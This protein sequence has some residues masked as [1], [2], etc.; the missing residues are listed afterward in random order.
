MAHQ[1]GTHSPSPSRGGLRVAQGQGSFQGRLV[2]HSPTMRAALASQNLALRGSDYSSEDSTSSPSTRRRSKRGLFGRRTSSDNSGSRKGSKDSSATQGT[3]GGHAFARGS[4]DTIAQSPRAD[5][6]ETPSHPSKEYGVTLYLRTPAPSGG[7]SREVYIKRDPKLGVGFTLNGEFPARILD[8]DPQSPAE[9]AG[10]LPGDEVH[11]V[12]GIHCT[13]VDHAH[14][15]KL[16]RKALSTQRTPSTPTISRSALSTAVSQSVSSSLSRQFDSAS[17]VPTAAPERV[18]SDMERQIRDRALALHS[19]NA[20]QSSASMRHHQATLASMD[21]TFTSQS[22]EDQELLLRVKATNDAKLASVSTSRP[23]ASASTKTQQDTSEFL[24]LLSEVDPDAVKPKTSPRQQLQHDVTTSVVDEEDFAGFDEVDITPADLEPSYEFTVEDESA[25][26]VSES[27]SDGYL[28]ILGSHSVPVLDSPHRGHTRSPASTTLPTSPLAHRSSLDFP[29][30]KTETQFLQRPGRSH[31]RTTGSPPS[32]SPSPSPAVGSPM[33]TRTRDSRRVH[34][35]RTSDAGLHVHSGPM[36][37]R[38]HSLPNAASGIPPAVLHPHSGQS[39]GRSDPDWLLSMVPTKSALK[40]PKSV[41]RRKRV[42]FSRDIAAVMT[43]TS[44]TK[45]QSARNELAPLQGTPP[46]ASG[47]PV[48]YSL[49]D[50]S[51]PLMHKRNLL[52]QA[53]SSPRLPRQKHFGAETTEQ[54]TSPNAQGALDVI[55]NIPPVLPGSARSSPLHSGPSS[56]SLP[57]Q[58]SHDSRGASLATPTAT[59]ATPSTSSSSH[60]SSVHTTQPISVQSTSTPVP[61]AGDVGTALQHPPQSPGVRANAVFL[62]SD[63]TGVEQ[64]ESITDG[65]GSDDCSLEPDSAGQAKQGDLYPGTTNVF[66]HKVTNN[67]WDVPEADYNPPSFT[68]PSVLSKPPAFIDPQDTV[69]IF[70]NVYD[71]GSRVDRASTLGAYKIV[72]GLPQNPLG[73][74]GMTG[75]GML[76]RWGPNKIK[77]LLLIRPCKDKDG[78][79]VYARDNSPVAEG[80]LANVDGLVLPGGYLEHLYGNEP[81]DSIVSEGTQQL[82]ALKSKLSTEHVL[83]STVPEAQEKFKALFTKCTVHSL[84]VTE[85][86]R[87]TDNAWVEPEVHVCVAQDDLFH[88]FSSKFTLSIGGL[89]LNLAW[90]RLHD[91]LFFAPQAASKLAMEQCQ[92]AKLSTKDMDWTKAPQEV[93]WL[94]YAAGKKFRG[95][96]SAGPTLGSSKTPIGDKWDPVRKLGSTRDFEMEKKEE[97]AQVT[98]SWM[99]DFQRKKKGSLRRNKQ[100]SA[101]AT[102]G[103]PEGLEPSQPETSGQSSTPVAT[104]EVQLSKPAV[105]Q[106]SAIVPDIQQDTSA[107]Q[108]TLTSSSTT[109]TQVASAKPVISQ[110]T[111]SQA[112]QQGAATAA[113]PVE[114]RSSRA[115]DIASKIIPKDA[116]VAPW[117]LEMQRKKLGGKARAPEDNPKPTDS[118]TSS[119]ATLTK[120]GSVSSRMQLWERAAK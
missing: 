84:P 98:A 33:L 23:P 76:P 20:T 106:E 60:T 55:Q 68:A 119:V 111:Q 78:N 114:R 100:P 71:N 102:A 45:P 107:S 116:E 117:I 115:A 53:R 28:E 38:S 14:V 93:Y 25:K 101:V 48:P 5:R 90:V 67:S 104:K 110:A 94:S 9:L 41:Q 32:T 56:Q 22:P 112:E 120:S 4:D 7:Y 47:L 37:T 58:F 105:S 82:D 69:S 63:P 83:G 97:E 109:A 118:S 19:K 62:L 99:K 10:V 24:A 81:Q 16:L 80:L 43:R 54:H 61:S 73:R 11:K 6:K 50:S 46:L 13:Q 70:F 59:F 91:Q 21:G 15:T 29:V 89:P 31:V 30:S 26:K 42:R 65:F 64:Y 36:A 95:A 57:T 79:S 92:R 17:P 75:R 35:N 3:T 12:E 52:E 88:S 113:A 66:R 34:R 77:Y 8:V 51:S 1:S 27:T 86:E 2:T 72:D 103:V 108:V 44:L 87:N 39:K 85:D 96:S 74:T 49:G 18:L 40:K